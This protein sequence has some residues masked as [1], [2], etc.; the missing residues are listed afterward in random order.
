[1]T[2]I[3]IS[4]SNIDNLTDARYFAA[5]M[6]TYLCMPLVDQDMGETMQL[7]EAIRPWISGA[8]WILEVPPALDLTLDDLR[9]LPVEGLLVHTLDSAIRLASTGREMLLEISEDEW[10]PSA[11]HSWAAVDILI[12]PAK[13]VHHWELLSDAVSDKAWIRVGTTDECRQVMALS[14]VPAGIFLTGSSET[15]TGFKS[16][17]ETDRLLDMVTGE[18]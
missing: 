15:K 9:D 4:A 18:G 10:D 12:L 5:Y 17:E 8:R 3:A 16:F 7:L 1:M 6:P 14:P 11:Q 13:A 2:D